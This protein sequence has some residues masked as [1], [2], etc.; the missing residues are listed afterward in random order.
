MDA[1]RKL[2]TSRDY[3]YQDYDF[4]TFN[5]AATESV[6]LNIE[7]YASLSTVK[8]TIS[9]QSVLYRAYDLNNDMTLS[10]NLYNT[11]VGTYTHNTP[12]TISDKTLY[13]SDTNHIE[14]PAP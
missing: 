4:S 3:E 12:T 1:V 6:F 10:D 9:P 2:D 11:F 8:N 14:C 5:F 7:T 13:L